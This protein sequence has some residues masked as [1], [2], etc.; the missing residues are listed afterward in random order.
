MERLGIRVTTDGFTVI[1]D[2][3]RHMNV[4]TE[5]KNLDGFRDLLVNRLCGPG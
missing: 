2:Q 3:A 4:A 5:W 1:D